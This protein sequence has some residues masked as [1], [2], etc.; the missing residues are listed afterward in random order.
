MATKA[1]GVREFKREWEGERQAFERLKVKLPRAL[2]GQFVAVSGSAVIDSDTDASALF[3]R[4][5]RS[6]DGRTFFIGR[7]DDA[8]AVVD[9]PGFSLA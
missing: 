3:D 9:M 4:V 8:D 1:V 7:V 5:A 6:L 2:R